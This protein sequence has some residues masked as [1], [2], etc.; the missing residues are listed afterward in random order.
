M[1][2]PG[3]AQ[4]AYVPGIEQFHVVG[5]DEQ[6]TRFRLAA[7]QL[8]GLAVLDNEGVRGHPGGVLAAGTEA[9]VAGH[10]VSTGYHDCLCRRRRRVG[11]DAA[12]RVD[13]D[14]A[15][16]LTRHA[17]RKGRKDATL[18]DN[19]AGAGVGLAEFFDDLDVSRQVEFRAPQGARQ[20]HVEQ[21]GVRQCLEERARQLP[22][23]VDLVGAGANFRGHFAG[24]IE[25]RASLCLQH[26]SWLSIMAGSNGFAPGQRSG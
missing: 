18:V 21:P 13:P 7:F 2:R 9:L 11:D 26:Q 3:A 20:G 16:H 8:P 1:V 23:G 14:R 6:V 22:V 17:G 4:A 19:P 25:Q 15:R 5:R 12:R 10:A 24:G